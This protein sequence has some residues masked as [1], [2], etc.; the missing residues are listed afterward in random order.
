MEF[1]WNISPID[2][3]RSLTPQDIEESFEDP[4]AVRLLPDSPRFSAQARYF[5][6][7]RSASGVGIFSVYRT[8]G[9][10]IRVICARPFS[11]EEQFFHQRKVNRMLAA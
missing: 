1:D 2:F 6:L 3:G 11:P 8:N 9:K 10:Q 4:F 5:N 7:G